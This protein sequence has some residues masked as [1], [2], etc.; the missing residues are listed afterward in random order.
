MINPLKAVDGF[1]FNPISPRQVALF[2]IFYSII[3]VQLAFVHLA[4]DLMAWYGKHAVV[5]ADV[6]REVH[7]RLFAHI[8]LLLLSQNDASVVALFWLF[9]FSIFCLMFGIASRLAAFTVFLCLVSFQNQNPFN[10]NS[11]DCLIRLT[12]FFLMFT[13]CGDAYSLS[14]VL[15]SWQRALH[16]DELAHRL[17]SPWA[18]RFLQLQLAIVYA[19]AT[20]SKAVAS[21]WQLGNAVYFAGRYE[22]MKRAV[23]P[24]FFDVPILWRILTWS[25]LVVE[26]SMT[27]LVWFPPLT[28]WVLLAGLGLH[29]GIETS[30]NIPMFQWIMISYYVL[31]LQPEDFDRV[32]QF[33]SHTVRTALSLTSVRLPYQQS[34][35]T[36]RRFVCLLKHFDVLRLVNVEPLTTGAIRASSEFGK[37]DGVVVVEGEK[38][39]RGFDGFKLLSA[40]IP[41]LWILL[42]FL[43][44]PLLSNIG[45][46]VF[47]FVSKTAR[48][49]IPKAAPPQSARFE[50]VLQCAAAAILLI[51][52]F[53]SSTLSTRPVKRDFTRQSLIAAREHF[54]QSELKKTLPSSQS[55]P[56]LKVQKDASELA[57]DSDPERSFYHSVGELNQLLDRQSN[58]DD[59]RKIVEAL[60]DL[61]AKSG[62]DIDDARL[63]AVSRLADVYWQDNRLDDAAAL[64]SYVWDKR[65]AKFK[66]TMKEDPDLL[67]T[68]LALAAIKRDAGDFATAEKYFTMGVRY[69]QRLYGPLD[70]DTLVEKGNLALTQYLLGQTLTDPSQREQKWKQSESLFDEVLSGLQLKFPHEKKLL[71]RIQNSRAVLVRDHHS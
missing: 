32:L 62:G 20:I 56:L 25:T 64:L 35:V 19:H 43:H 57:K 48:N 14:R 3:L 68:V 23:I 52:A 22:E 34:S 58:K 1:F 31:F 4:P 29:L 50:V 39:V 17:S 15:R 33:V 47:E 45:K 8:N 16:P 63:M 46:F 11:G 54:A 10:C 24:F 49:S 6:A 28:R 7:H 40:R 71:E 12:A 70:R 21:D 67:A 65:T 36:A 9:V 38:A 18:Q 2:R 5:P 27:L 13:K 37:L 60:N 55:E 69:K 26:A 51:L 30:M 42:P 61:D 44:L 41:V 59:S 66:Q 53:A